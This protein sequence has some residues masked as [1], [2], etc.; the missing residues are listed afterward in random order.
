MLERQRVVLESRR[1][2]GLSQV[3]RVVGFRGQADIRQAELPDQASLLEQRGSHRPLA[4]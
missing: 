4:K 3:P 2:V 1:E